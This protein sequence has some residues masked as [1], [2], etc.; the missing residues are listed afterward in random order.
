MIENSQWLVKAP[1]ANSEGFEVFRFAGPLPTMLRIR[2]L[3]V[4]D[5]IAKTERRCLNSGKASITDFDVSTAPW[6]TREWLQC[7]SFAPGLISKEAAVERAKHHA[8]YEVYVS[9]KDQ[10]FFFVND[11]CYGLNRVEGKLPEHWVPCSFGLP[12]KVTPREGLESGWVQTIDQ[13]I[14]VFESDAT[15]IESEDQLNVILKGERNA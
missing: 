1:K 7:N 10:A 4:Y 9:L 5:L 11:Y 13:W 15:L 8:R 14:F 3:F 2:A 6:V 12:M